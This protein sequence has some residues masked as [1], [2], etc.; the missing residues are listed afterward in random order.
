MNTATVRGRRTPKRPTLS[1]A[2]AIA[3][4]SRDSKKK[5]YVSDD[6]RNRWERIVSK[7]RA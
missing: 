4:M 7:G 1:A 6:L 3:S 2:H 5:I